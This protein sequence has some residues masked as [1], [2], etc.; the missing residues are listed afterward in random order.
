MSEAATA[1]PIKPCPSCPTGSMERF[2]SWPSLSAHLV[3]DHLMAASKAMA[4]AKN[5]FEGPESAVSEPAIV[6]GGSMS[7]WPEV[8]ASDFD[9]VTSQ[10]PPMPIGVPKS[11]GRKCRGCGK[12]SPGHRMPNCPE[13]LARKAPTGGA[14]PSRAAKLPEPGTPVAVERYQRIVPPMLP[15]VEPLPLREFLSA[16]AVGLLQKT[17]QDMRFRAAQLLE[18][19]D[20]LRRLLAPSLGH[21][22]SANGHQVSAPGRSPKAT[23]QALAAG[24][25]ARKTSARG[26]GR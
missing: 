20:A 8:T 7:G 23:G 25:K 14:L 16:P 17:E 24:R 3:N 2:L 5:I 18:S 15:T 4:T 9:P 12:D 21:P 13:V 11:G 6:V 1:A 26:K 22:M 19:A 10:E